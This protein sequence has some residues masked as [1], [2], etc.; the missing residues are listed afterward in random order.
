MRLLRTRW[1]PRSLMICR[2]YVHAIVCV[3]V[4][5]R[6]QPQQMWTAT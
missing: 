3:C 1:L 4:S 5:F 2:A 6:L